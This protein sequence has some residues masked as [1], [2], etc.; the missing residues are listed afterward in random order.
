MTSLV[1]DGE[2]AINKNP[3]VKTASGHI[4]ALGTAA[5]GGASALLQEDGSS[6]ILLETGDHTL[7]E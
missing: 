7:V 4:V 3:L 6:F 2:F 5:A 1:F